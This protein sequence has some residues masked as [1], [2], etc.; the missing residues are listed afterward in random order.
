[1]A[2]GRCCVVMRKETAILK[3]ANTVTYWGAPTRGCVFF[4]KRYLNVFWD[5]VRMGRQ[6][7]SPRPLYVGL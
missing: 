4:A 5:L 6:S 7:L 3:I 2:R 1:M